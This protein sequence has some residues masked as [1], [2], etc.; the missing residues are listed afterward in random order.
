MIMET[1][2]RGLIARPP[3]IQSR[4]CDAWYRAF[5]RLS[6]PAAGAVAALLFASMAARA[7]EPPAAYAFIGEPY[8]ITAE[9][10]DPHRFVLNFF[11]LSEYVIVVQPSEFIYKSSSGQFYIGQVFDLPTKGTRGDSY[12]YSASFLL[13]S[14]SYKGLDILGAF[15]DQDSIEELSIRIG[16]KRYYLQPLNRSQ[17]SELDKKIENLDLTNQNVQ[18]AFRDAG[19]T[20]LGRVTTT[21]GTPEWDRDWQGLLLPEGINPPK[22]INMPDMSPTDEARRTNTYGKVRLSAV[23]T[24]D[25]TILDVSV[26][27]GLGRGLDERAVAGV[28]ANWVFL[29]ATKNGEVIETSAKFDV[30]FSPPKS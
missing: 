15:H 4:N 21:D 2:G 26:V 18:A 7:G 13:G 23:I 29:P 11:N 3:A 19:L 8:V 14:F 28:K 20:A 30:T 5:Q 10:A 27:K 1:C 22:I 9:V 16:A 12:R 6:R 24:R 25:G 17:F